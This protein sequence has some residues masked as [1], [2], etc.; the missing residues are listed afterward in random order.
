M[1]LPW[2]GLFWKR[3]DLPKKI[4]FHI[5]DFKMDYLNVPHDGGFSDDLTS[6]GDIDFETDP[7]S[8]QR[9]LENRE[10]SP[11]VLKFRSSLTPAVKLHKSLKKNKVKDLIDKGVVY[12]WRHAYFNILWPSPCCHTFITKLTHHRPPSLR[13]RRHFLTAINRFKR[14]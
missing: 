14:P 11:S 3:Q 7:R 1:K 10:L 13:L 2:L 4:L 9:I 6:Q 5:L 8:L 12:K